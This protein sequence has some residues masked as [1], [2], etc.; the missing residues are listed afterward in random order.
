METIGRAD[1][2]NNLS[3]TGWQTDVE[4][5][6]LSL[7][8][9]PG[10]RVFSL[11][12]ADNVEGNWL[13]A[14]SLLDLFLLLIFSLAVFRLWGLKAGIV[15]LLAFGLSCHEPGAPRL[16]WLFLLMPIALL[17][18]VGEASGKRWLNAWKFLAVA[19]LVLNFVPFVAR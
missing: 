12:G 10:W 3:A 18:V 7:S 19:L 9:S 8:L 1:L 2:T 16:T 11:F 13:T 15:A 14:W 5:L 17:R 4:S 6:H